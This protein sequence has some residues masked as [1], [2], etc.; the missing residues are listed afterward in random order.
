M[1]EL[2][3]SKLNINDVYPST[4]QYLKAGDLQGHSVKVIIESC[5]TA[6]FKEGNKV[7]LKFKGKEKEMVMNPTNARKIGEYYGEETDH[8]IGKEIII[9]PDKT[10]FNNQM[11]DCLRVR[12]EAPM[13]QEDDIPGF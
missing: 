4:S 9:Y 1:G 5:G 13:A 12:V 10:E 11:V 7:A 3:G 6:E 2:K 8:W